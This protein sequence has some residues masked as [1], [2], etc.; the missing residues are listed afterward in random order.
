MNDMSHDII[1]YVQPHMPRWTDERTAECVSLWKGG[2]S[3]GQIAIKLGG[4]TRN[5]VI[6]KLHR[7]GIN[8]R[9]VPG[10]PRTPRICRPPATDSSGVPIGLKLAIAGAKITNRPAPTISQS[11]R[12]KPLSAPLIAPDRPANGVSFIE[13]T[14]YT[15]RFPIGDVGTK[16]F[17]FCGAKK[18]REG[19][20]CDSCRAKA[21]IGVP[22]SSK[23]FLN[24]TTAR[25]RKGRLAMLAGQ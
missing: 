24:F 7:M 11:K 12:L 22:K 13:L 10:R 15:C 1:A 19:P 3:A 5:A 20:Y 18:E 25:A 9:N 4:T 14:E 2:A 8:S 16:S 23:P 17:S 21:Y 6:G